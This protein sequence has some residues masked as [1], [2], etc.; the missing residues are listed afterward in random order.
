MPVVVLVDDQHLRADAIALHLT[1]ATGVTVVARYGLHR[2]ALLRDLPGL[3]PDVI[4]IF[5]E[6]AGPPLPTLIGNIRAAYPEG[7]ILVLAEG[8]DITLVV[9]AARAGADSWVEPSS[10]FDQLLEALHGLHRGEASFPAVQLGAVVRALREDARKAREAR[11]RSSPLDALSRREREVLHHIVQGKKDSVIAREL[12]IS[13]NTVRTHTAN[14]LA[15]LNVHSRLEAASIARAAG[16]EV[17]NGAGQITANPRT[18]GRH[19]D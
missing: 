16:M 14:I 17:T 11:E 1:A 19:G 15:K 6:K 3:R 5:V 4:M 9:A 10:S 13:P 7:Q 2:A 8:A 18:A 12:S